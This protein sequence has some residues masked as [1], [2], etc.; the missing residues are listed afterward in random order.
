MGSSARGLESK[1][2]LLR[3]PTRDG[4]AAGVER[5]SD[6]GETVQAALEELGIE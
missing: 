2:C 1:R 6:E 5:V 3:R 4:Y